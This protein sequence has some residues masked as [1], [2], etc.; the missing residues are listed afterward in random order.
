MRVIARGRLYGK[1]FGPEATCT[2]HSVLCRLLQRPTSKAYAGP[3]R[4][5]PRI[6]EQI[7]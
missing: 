2:V 6:V 4:N 3:P 1:G 5:D 7:V